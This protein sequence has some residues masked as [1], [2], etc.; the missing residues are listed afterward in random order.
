VRDNGRGLVGEPGSGVGLSNIRERLQ[1]LYGGAAS[2]QLS[3]QASGGTLAQVEIPDE[4]GT[5]TA[6]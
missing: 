3:A 4:P 5:R 1:V 6:G 2:V